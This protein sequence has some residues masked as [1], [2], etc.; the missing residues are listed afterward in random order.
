MSASARTGTVG[1]TQG[2]SRPL[3]PHP[4]PPPSRTHN[5]PWICSRRYR[6]GTAVTENDM[7]DPRGHQGGRKA[8]EE[9]GCTKTKNRRPLP[10]LAQ[11]RCS[12]SPV[13][14]AHS[15]A[16]PRT[17]RDMSAFCIARTGPSWSG[18]RYK[19]Q[20]FDKGCGN[21]I[22]GWQ[23]RGTSGFGLARSLTN[24]G[25]GKE[26]DGVGI[27]HRNVCNKSEK[28]SDE[29]GRSQKNRNSNNTKT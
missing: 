15:F 17:K 8:R 14:S 29:G 11:F 19:N 28:E 26:L 23:W 13:S 10:G 22:R 21:S 20:T 3:T 7:P 25:D 18:A 4:A 16:C 5:L 24:H 12:Q 6:G 2:S 1:T 27:E 9:I